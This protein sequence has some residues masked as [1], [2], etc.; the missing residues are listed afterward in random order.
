MTASPL[1]PS[2]TADNWAT[3]PN[4]CKVPG[5]GYTPLY[6]NNGNVNPIASFPITYDQKLACNNVVYTSKVVDTSNQNFAYGQLYAWKD[7][8]DVLYVTVS[9][10]ATGFGPGATISQARLRLCL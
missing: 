5:F 7:Y 4:Q 1:L 10:N 8:S 9:L 2:Q 3:D 6:V